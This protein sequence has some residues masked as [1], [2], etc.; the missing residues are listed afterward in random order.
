MSIHDIPRLEN[1][2]A[3]DLAQI[4]SGYKISKEK[5]QEVIEVRGRIAPTKLTPSDLESTRLGYMDSENFEILAIDSLS[6]EDGRKPIVEYLKSPSPS[7]ERKIRHR[8]LSFFIMGNELF[9]KT[10]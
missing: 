1:Q 2:E 7:V 5:L 10:P 6:D 3:N 8:S 4:A 9:K